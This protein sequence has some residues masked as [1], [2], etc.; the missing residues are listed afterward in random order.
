MRRLDQLSEKF[1]FRFYEDIIIAKREGEKERE[2]GVGRGEGEGR[3]EDKKRKR[4]SWE[5]GEWRGKTCKCKKDP[6]FIVFVGYF[7]P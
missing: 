6:I 5:G 1:P 2:G 3:R 7:T 4:R